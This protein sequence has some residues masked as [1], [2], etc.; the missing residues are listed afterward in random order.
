MHTVFDRSF[1]HLPLLHDLL[2]Q[3]ENFCPKNYMAVF[4]P[5]S[6]T[7]WH[8]NKSL[9]RFGEGWNCW[10][11]K[12]QKCHAWQSFAKWQSE[13]AIAASIICLHCKHCSLT[14]LFNISTILCTGIQEPQFMR[15]HWSRQW[16]GIR[17]I[18]HMEIYPM[19]AIYGNRWYLK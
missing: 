8:E 9:N 12:S 4:Y 6:S 11:S 7:I 18:R 5:M 2:P 17:L 19:S 16:H 10:R 1:V 3:F 15:W 14:F 13:G